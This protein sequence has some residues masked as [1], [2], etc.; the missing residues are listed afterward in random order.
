MSGPPRGRETGKKPRFVYILLTRSNSLD[1][2]IIPPRRSASLSLL[3]EP[4]HVVA[5]S[6]P[7]QEMH[8]TRKKKYIYTT[9]DP[10]YSPPSSVHTHTH[11]HT[12]TH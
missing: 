8:Q 1:P 4:T 6:K 2:D 9:T 10:D 7:E 11:T 12:H 3:F 5:S